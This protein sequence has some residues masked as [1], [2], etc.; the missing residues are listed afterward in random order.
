MK[1][2]LLGLLLAGSCF[3]L[4]DALAVNSVVWDGAELVYGQG[5]VY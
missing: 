4:T 2:L 5:K 1:K 3:F